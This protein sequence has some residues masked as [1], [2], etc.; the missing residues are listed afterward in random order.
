MDDG[1]AKWLGQGKES[2]LNGSETERNG[3]ERKGIEC[4]REKERNCFERRQS[5]D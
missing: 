5:F 4:V 2:P 1:D 3:K